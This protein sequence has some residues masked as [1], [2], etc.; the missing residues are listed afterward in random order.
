[1]LMIPWDSLGAFCNQPNEFQPTLPSP[2]SKRLWQPK[3]QSNPEFL[4]FLTD[5]RFPKWKGVWISELQ[6]RLCCHTLDKA[7]L[8]NVSYKCLTWPS[9]W[10]L[11]SGFKLRYGTRTSNWP[12][13]LNSA[14]CVKIPVLICLCIKPVMNY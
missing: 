12:H 1:M 14:T 7:S 5:L 6:N 11:N 4:K 8:F 9:I 13:F 2:Y 3:L 10:K